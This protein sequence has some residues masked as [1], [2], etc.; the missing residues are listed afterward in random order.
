MRLVFL[1]PPGAG[2]GTQSTRLQQKFNIPQLSTGDMLRAAV[3]AGT[4]VGLKAKAIMDA[5]GLVPDEVVVG[6]IADRIDEPDAKEGFIL[7]GFPRTVKQAE[8][9]ADI[10]IKK[11]MKLDAVI[12]LKVDDKA[13][14]ARIENRAQ[15]SLAKGETIR[16]DDNPE[17]FKKRLES[18]HAQTAPVSAFYA[19]KG[20]LKAVDGMAPIDDVSAAIEK[21]LAF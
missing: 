21:A 8:A 18:Y 9:L 19:G 4:P 2:K 5:G 6:I 16:A 13:L 17:A 20:A 12:E 14:L 11:N 10:L 7:D 15:E 3:K 1:G